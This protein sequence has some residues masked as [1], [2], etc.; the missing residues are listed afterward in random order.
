MTTTTMTRFYTAAA[1][2]TVDDGYAVTLDGR[3]VKTPKRRC[4]LVVP[5]APLAEAIAA[6]WAAQD[7]TVD[8]ATMPLTALASTALDLAG[9]RSDLVSA[10]ARHG[11]TD[12]VCYWV[13]EHGTLRQRQQTHWQPLLDWVALTYD[14]RLNVTTGI[15]PVSQPRDATKALADAVDALEDF[16]LAALSSAVAATTSLV[17]GLALLDR[18]IDADTAFDTAELEST[19]Q[20]E[21]WGEDAEAADRRARIHTD[22][23]AV[24]RFRDALAGA[25]VTPA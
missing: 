2:S 20:I 24:E 18:R 8:P 1:S 9:H 5:S 12:P 3:T 21:Q 6:E 10:I 16:R 22:L 14:A 11:E 19:F 25:R 23:H 15:L 13:P 4:P 17:I 7:T